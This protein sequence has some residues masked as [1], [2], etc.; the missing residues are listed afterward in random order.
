MSRDIILDD[1]DNTISPAPDVNGDPDPV[2]TGGGTPATTQPVPGPAALSA[3]LGPPPTE[4]EISR[5]STRITAQPVPDYCLM[6]E[7]E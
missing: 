7:G 1:T 3:P 5:D 4:P 6:H 2:P